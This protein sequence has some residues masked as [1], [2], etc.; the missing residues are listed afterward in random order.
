L[1]FLQ[2]F[3]KNLKNNRKIIYFGVPQMWNGLFTITAIDD[4]YCSIFNWKAGN[5]KVFKLSVLKIL[6]KKDS[7]LL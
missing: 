1:N 4:H 2:N 5:V 7:S 3:A 6:V